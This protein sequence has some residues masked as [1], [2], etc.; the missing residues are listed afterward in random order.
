MAYN[1]LLVERMRIELDLR[2]VDYRELK[3]MGGMAF[4]VDDK[5]CMGAMIDKK[6]DQS[7]MLVRINPADYSSLLDLLACR[8]FDFT[9]RPMKGFLAVLD[10]SHL[11]EATLKSWVERCLEYNPLA[12]ASKKKKKS[13]T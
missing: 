3:M 10:D 6:D 9:G 5:M 11:D 4:M 1:E 8:P 2:A 13:K 12:K 7:I